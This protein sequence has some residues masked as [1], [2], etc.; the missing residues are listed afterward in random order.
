MILLNKVN[1]VGFNIP[2]RFS[3][4]YDCRLPKPFQWSATPFSNNLTIGRCKFWAFAW[5]KKKALQWRSSVIIIIVIQSISECTQAYRAIN[6]GKRWP[7][8]NAGP[9]QAGRS[10]LFFAQSNGNNCGG[11]PRTRR[12]SAPHCVPR[13]LLPS[14]P[15]SF[16]Y[17]FSQWP[18][19]LKCW[20]IQRP[21]DVAKDSGLWAEML[22]CWKSFKLLDYKLRIVYLI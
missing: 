5:T 19:S 14:W 15:S 20:C 1:P 2:F 6:T 17:P 8:I 18:H 10:A 3:I 22:S 16:S 12:R 13:V 9:H 4:L 11:S 21:I 7:H